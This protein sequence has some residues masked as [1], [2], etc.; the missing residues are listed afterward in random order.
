MQK[1]LITLGISMG[2][3]LLHAQPSVQWEKNYGGSKDDYISAIL[4]TVDGGCITVGS[5]LSSDGDVG[6]NYG[7]ND[8]WIMKLNQNGIIEWKKVIGGNKYDTGR[9]I[10]YA[11]D[12]GY[13]ILGETGSTN[14]GAVEIKGKTDFWIIKLDASGNLLWQKTLGGSEADGLF[15]GVLASDGGFI[16]AGTTKSNDGDILQHFGETYTYDIWIGKFDSIGNLEWQRVLGNTEDDYVNCLVKT[17]DGEYMIG[18]LL[19]D[20]SAFYQSSDAWIV[21][22]NEDGQILWDRRLGGTNT[23]FTRALQPSDAG[24]FY[25]GIHSRSEDGE[26]GIL[27]R[28]DFEY[29]V[30]KLTDQGKLQ[31]SKALGCLGL[32]EIYDLIQTDNDGVI[33]GGQ[34]LGYPNSDRTQSIDYQGHD[35]WLIKLNGNGRL[36]WET[37]LGTTSSDFL[38]KMVQTADSGILLGGWIDQ[39]TQTDGFL[40]KLSID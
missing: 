37:T 6:V 22:F 38:R 29:A 2:F 12:G 17:S 25:A 18:G 32:D 36:E 26:A 11:Q 13:F 23:D 34:T 9:S 7:S 16:V 40:I 31:W 3:Y 15:R 33:V 39:I 10:F 28:K 8:C 21:K 19:S 5:S 24:G 35:I 20:T 27:P 14:G 1:L 4:P 30:M